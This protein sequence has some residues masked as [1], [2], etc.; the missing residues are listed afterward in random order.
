MV[1]PDNGTGLTRRSVSAYD[2]RVHEIA[3][4]L[5]QH[6][7]FDTLDDEELER[8]AAACQIEFVPGETVIIAQG[9][10]P[11]P[12]A[13]V[14]RRGSVSLLDEGHVIDLLGEGEMFG[15]TSV[16]VEG[17]AA[18]AVVAH[19][20]T[21]CYRL[22]AEVLRN[23]LARPAAL[24]Y[25]ARSLSGRFEM[26]RDEFAGPL[27]DPA[28][29]P[30][31]ELLRGPAVIV[32]PADSVQEA[33]T[34]M[35]EAG[36]SSL[37]VDTGN[38]L[39]IVT[40]RDLRQR[41]VAAG[42]GPDMPIGEVMTQ[43]VRTVGGDTRGSE[44]LLEMLDRGIRHLVV[45]DSH[46]KVIGV[47][48]DTDLMAVETRT[49]FHLR[50]AIARAGDVDAL[51]AVMDD[52]PATV[53]ALHDAHTPA[54]VLGRV[55]S[56]VQEAATR[57]MLEL[58]AER[59]GPAPRRFSWFAL[60]SL[61]R[62]ESAPSS[63]QDSAL[64]WEGDDDPA[65]REALTERAAFVVEGL[66][67]S[68]VPACDHGVLASRPLFARPVDDWVTLVRS[69]LS[70]PDQEK[71]LIFTSVIVEGRAVWDADVVAGTIAR[72]L[73]RAR[74]HPYL[75][76]RMAIFALAHQ[77]PTGFFRE[78]VLEQGGERKGTLDIKRG[79]LL[80]VV[81]LAR[82]AA[83]RAGVTAAS[84]AERLDAAEQAGSL[85]AADVA[86]LRIAFD[87]FTQ[88]RMQHQVD[89]LRRGARPDDSIDPRRLDP[90]TRRYLKE[91]F[92]AVERVQRGVANEMGLRPR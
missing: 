31:A 4:F 30:V 33:A 3:D 34:R 84:T 44:A 35:V 89:A 54:T 2:G 36:M 11:R 25:V 17:P 77:P 16:L 72:E 56:A 7:P 37:L 80:P 92:R 78:F 57:R 81:D 45:L 66:K 82:W 38:G 53:I 14:V 60:G 50:T 27:T 32:A 5:G 48:S 59:F 24:R 6:P 47:V 49:P 73:E 20:D 79:G 64:A 29:R 15:H 9:E 68:G 90:L 65:V 39:G 23:V 75:L 67:R 55:I 28:Q 85:P 76:Q 62:R 61:A 88:L 52:M 8:V 10:G 71:A 41:V 26:R 13:H 42:A 12:H 74:D 70:D 43:P 18:F 91:S 58:A 40:D 22:P 83:M 87:L 63:D 69:M 86:T 51:A 46:R 19:E 21:L 1:S